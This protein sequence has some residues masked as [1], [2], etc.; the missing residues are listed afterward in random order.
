MLPNKTEIR[1]DVEPF[2]LCP[3]QEICFVELIESRSS[4]CLSGVYDCVVG[5]S[6]RP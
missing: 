6:Q 1:R 5:D 4:Q 3:V 2:L